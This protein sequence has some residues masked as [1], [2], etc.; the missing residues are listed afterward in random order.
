M[1]S[2]WTAG[3]ILAMT[4]A[5]YAVPTNT[6][7]SGSPGRGTCASTCHGSAGG[8]VQISGFPAEYVPDSTYL[9]TIQRMSGL[10]IKNFNAS[11]RIG[12]GTQNAGQLSGGSHTSTYSVAGETNGIHLSQFDQVSATF[13]W[14]APAAGTGTVRLYVGAHQGLQPGPNTTIVAIAAEL[15]VPQPP[16]AAS[17]PQPASGAIDQLLSGIE[18]SWQPGARAETHD[19]YFGVAGDSLELLVENHSGFTVFAPDPLAPGATYLWRVDSRNDAGTTTGETWSFAT[20]VLPNAS[21]NPVPDDGAIEIPLN[22]VLSWS[23]ADGAESYNVC[24]GTTNP[25]APLAQGLTD[26]SYDLTGVIDFATTYF[27]EIAAVN[28]IGTTPGPIWSFVT[29]ANAA[30]DRGPVVPTELSLG[31]VYPNPFNAETTI[32]FVLPHAGQVRLEMF[33]ML[34]RRVAV[35]ANTNF[36]A[37]SHALRWSSASVSTG[38]YLL[39]LTSGG[40]ELTA[41]VIAVK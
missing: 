9:I 41:R 35:L 1:K 25:P 17:D 28:A 39:K 6:G 21:G 33:D 22:A 4:V 23:V 37:G 31:P 27:W 14:Q 32:P 26:T 24:F 7:Y 38:V 15:V 2:I 40:Q 5:L 16:E 18:L 11:C 20:G 10:A 3:I 19:I 12:T 8:T 29:T 30:N 34:G 36:P 13:N